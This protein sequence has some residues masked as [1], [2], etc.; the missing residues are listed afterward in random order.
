VIG[1][2]I[3]FA[4]PRDIPYLEEIF[5][6]K[7]R[8]WLDRASWKIDFPDCS[9]R[10]KAI[11]W[12]EILKGYDAVITCWSSPRLDGNTL[13]PD[14][15]IRIV[16]H[17]AGSVAGIVSPE[18]YD[19]GIRVTTANE[20]MAQAV[21]DWCLTVTLL[22]VRRFLDYTS[23]GGAGSLRWDRKL[24]PGFIQDAKI[25]IW[26][27]GAVA[28]HFIRMLGPLNPA[29]ILVCDDFLSEDKASVSR[30]R[31]VG[32]DEVFSRADVVVLLQA[33]REDTADRVGEKELGRIRDGAVFINCGRAGLVREEAL[34][35]ELGKGRFTGILDVYH[36]EPLPGNSPLL[37]MPN[38]VLTPHNAGRP[39][40]ERY[41]PLIL[42]EFERFFSGKPLQH[43]ITRERAAA[44]TRLI[45][46][47]RGK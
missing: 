38:V 20:M 16:G 41:V 19:R 5:G 42:A 46:R 43:E 11:P 45:P 6:R 23:F 3:V 39:G 7:A 47:S 28:R 14:S 4:V 18:L 32:L 8:E 44:M 30:I 2:S 26:G 22:G 37:R 1:P 9:V 35:A 36:E 17:A 21:A 15:T 34:I 10:D 24:R 27:Y 12:R 13:A 31:K 29:E 40:R 33:L 25:G